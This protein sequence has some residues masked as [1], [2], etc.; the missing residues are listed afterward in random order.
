MAEDGKSFVERVEA[1]KAQAAQQVWG[2]AQGSSAIPLD[3][4]VGG[5]APA[6]GEE[7]AE[8]SIGEAQENHS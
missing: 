6:M 4:G 2:L 1:G 3:L 5:L 7:G 8:R